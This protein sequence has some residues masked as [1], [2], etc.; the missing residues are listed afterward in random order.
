[1][2]HPYTTLARVQTFAIAQHVNA[3][4]DRDA[5]GSADSGVMDAAIERACNEIDSRLG[6]R[7]EVPFA[8]LSD[9]P[10]KVSDIADRLALVYLL[11]PIEGA[12][13]HVAHHWKVA[14]DELAR[15]A[16]GSAH[17]PGATLVSTQSRRPVRWE[18][19]GTHV[20]GRVDDDYTTSG[21][22]K[23]HGI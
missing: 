16:D 6:F 9:T 10:G 22:D 12:S 4:L 2:A 5:D 14:Q 11:E 21:T 23:S 17:L 8:S 1:M 19:A 3:Y 7:F 13:D 20:A 18:S 15:L